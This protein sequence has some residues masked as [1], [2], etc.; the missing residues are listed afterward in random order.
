MVRTKFPQVHLIA[1]TENTGFSRANNQAIAQSTGSYVLLLNPDTILPEDGLE[2]VIRFME[3][4]PQAGALGAKMVDG[5]GLFLPESKRGLPTPWVSFCKAFGLAAIFPNSPTFG[6]YHLSYLPENETHEVDVLSGAFMLMRREALTKA[7]LLDEQFFMYGEDVDLS[8]RIQQAGYKNFYFPGTT[9]IH[10]KGESTKRGSISFVMHFYRAML[11]F[12]RKH[13]SNR[14][15]FSFFI[16]LGIAVRAG[17][18]LVQRFFRAYGGFL[19][20]FI[21]AY[22]GMVVIKEWWEL[23]FKGVPGMYPDYFIQLLV[24]GYLV[25]WLGCTRLIGQYSENYGHAAIVKG[26]VLGTIF[27]SG[28]TNFFDD[29][30]FSKG[31]ILIGAVWTYF[32]ATTRYL[33]AQWLVHRDASLKF[34]TR[35]RILLVGNEDDFENA[36]Q[37]LK[38]NED[39][40][41]LTGWISGEAPPPT[42]RHCLGSTDDLTELT[43]RI[44]LQE[45]MFCLPTFP[46]HRAIALMEKQKG[47]RL[48][49]TFLAKGSQFM[50][51]S[52]EKHSR[53]TV[54]QS[55]NIPTILLPYN[56]RLK[57]LIDLAGCLMV[58]F[59]W[60]VIVA[61]GGSIAQLIQNFGQV[62]I[63]RKSWIGLANNHLKSFGLKD[64]VVRT[65]DLAGKNAK[66]SLVQALDQI[67][68]NEFYPTQELWAMLKNPALLGR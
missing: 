21:A 62:L 65:V 52:S 1:N 32:I 19:L 13:F 53:G 24:P 48:R 27:I 34:P 56:R 64:G 35:K 20:E 26:I 9:I 7:G 37:L 36:V 44:G 12:S 14:I 2:K 58:L 11:L 51:S 31:L 10:F 18:A 16:Y 42:H 39:Q 8:F 29:Y 54:F 67:Y 15:F 40:L 38:G 25:A 59:Y 4:H 60:P 17:L 55:E 61:K 33:L 46:A 68:A 30:R 23:N 50:V 49:F 3:T 41:V 22:L 47:L 63:G 28:V 5:S 6:R 66:P 43:Y 45:L 57:R